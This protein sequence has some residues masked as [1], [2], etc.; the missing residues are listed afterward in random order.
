MSEKRPQLFVN[1]CNS[2]AYELEIGTKLD[3]DGLPETV[4][5]L[6]NTEHYGEYTKEQFEAQFQK[7]E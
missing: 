5:R 4:Y 7:F 1:K 3:A 6:K 2:E